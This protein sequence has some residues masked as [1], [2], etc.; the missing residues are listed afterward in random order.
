MT[1]NIKFPQTLSYSDTEN[2]ASNSL[3]VHKRKLVL[4]TRAHPESFTMP[5]GNNDEEV[6]NRNRSDSLTTD[7]SFTTTSKAANEK[8]Y[9]FKTKQPFSEMSSGRSTPTGRSG[10]KKRHRRREPKF[11]DLSEVEEVSESFSH[12]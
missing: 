5:A 1:E 11:G 2:I 3:N 7:Q 4:P 6:V 12:F 10:R 8:G 9:V